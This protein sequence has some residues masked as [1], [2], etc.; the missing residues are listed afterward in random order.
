MLVT[1]L[2]RRASQCPRQMHLFS[3]QPTSPPPLTPAAQHRHKVTPYASMGLKGR[4]LATFVRGSQVF[5][6]EAGVAPAACGT[7]QL[8]AKRR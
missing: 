5:G 4:V 8:H 3:P 7:T 6:E 2:V 1:P